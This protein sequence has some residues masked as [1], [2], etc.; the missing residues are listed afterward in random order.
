MLQCKCTLEILQVVLTSDGTDLLKSQ[1]S[2]PLVVVNLPE[3]SRPTDTT[4]PSGGN[5]NRLLKFTVSRSR[6]FLALTTGKLQSTSYSP[7]NPMM[8]LSSWHTLTYNGKAKER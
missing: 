5:S 4:L 3:I 8:T 1:F 7:K 2:I 6:K